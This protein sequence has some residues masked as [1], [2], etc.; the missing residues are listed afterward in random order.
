MK[1]LFPLTFAILLISMISPLQAQKA[2]GLFRGLKQ[3]PRTIT[4]A[5][6][7]T[8][9]QALHNKFS[10]PSLAKSTFTLKVSK[11]GQSPFRYGEES[12]ASAFVFEEKYQG[13]TYLWGATASHYFFQNP[14]LKNPQTG[15]EIPVQF[16]AQGHYNMNDVSLFLIPLQLKDQ[17]TPLSLAPHAPQK[18]EK[19][20]SASYFDDEFHVEKNRVVTDI[21]PT[22]ILTLLT[23][24]KNLSRE[25]ACGGPILNK[26]GTIVGMHVGSS[27]KRQ[28]GFIVPVEHIYEVLQAYHNNGKALRPFY[29]NGR[30]IGNININEYIP[31]IDVWQG[32]K[33]IQEVETYP[34]RSYLDYNH[35][36][37]FVD[38]SHAD[39]IVFVV[40]RIPFSMLEADQ[41]VRRFEITYNLR[42]FHISRRE[43]K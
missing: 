22:R 32:N 36:E 39:K 3:K 29:F 18:G 25:G 42:N 1:R 24:E 13:Q 21:L 35:L 14:T 43:I 20:L 6:Q 41:H 15:E 12:D 11:K 38:A 5:T 40:E 30:Q 19:L 28:A 26:Q 27:A 37:T 7:R 33:K 4:L 8:L 34:N 10:P 17:F 23:V 2:K 31:H 9:N 16:V